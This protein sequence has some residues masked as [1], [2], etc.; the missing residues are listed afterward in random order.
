MR[1]KVAKISAI[2]RDHPTSQKTM[3]SELATRGYTR[4]PGTGVFKFPYKERD[5][6]Y[7]TGLDPDAS[8]IRRIEDKTQRDL[9]IKRVTELKE[10][11][12][13]EL[14]LDLGPKSEFWNYAKAKSTEDY[15]HVRP[16][17]LLDGDNI[18]DLNDL[19]QELTFSWLRVHPSIA[20]SFQAWQR[21]EYPAD[22]QFYVADD[23]IESELAFNKKQAINKA[24]V[25]LDSMTPEKR[26]KVGRQ[27]GLV[28][29]ENTK[30]SVAYNMIDTYLK[31]S[32]DKSAK[33]RGE[34]PAKVFMKYATMAENLLH[35]KDLIN[36]AITHSIYRVQANGKL[37]EGSNEI[38]KTE[39]D[40]VKYLLADE[41]QEDLLILEEKLKE[42]KLAFV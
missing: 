41:H 11:F 37:Y 22:T 4:V 17:K 16:V 3:Q 19:W 12:E 21:G 40:F 9:E 1:K 33:H 7:R 6:K 31:S 20:S 36:Q 13:K 39:D 14:N 32:E 34:S 25:S 23:E 10:K 5:G 27:L 35:V 18:Y 8:Y 26:R 42:K 2:K 28:I 30:D 38:A 15:Q 29:S 24:I